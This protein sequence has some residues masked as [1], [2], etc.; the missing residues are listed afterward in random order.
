MRLAGRDGGGMWPLIYP[1]L[2]EMIRREAEAPD[3]LQDHLLWQLHLSHL[4][5]R[6]L[7]VEPG[8]GQW[9]RHL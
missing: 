5:D 6:D 7:H 8:T 3:G 2:L 1:R 9:Q 4:H